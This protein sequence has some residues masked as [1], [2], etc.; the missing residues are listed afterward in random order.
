MY[1][2]YL[3]N[4]VDQFVFKHLLGM[5]VCYKETDIITLS[6]RMM[7][8][9]LKYNHYYYTVPTSMGFLLKTKKCSARIIMKCMNFLHNIFSISSA[10]KKR[11]KE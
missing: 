1:N 6:K 9:I 2:V 7:N 10:F 11:Q 8:I 5:K 3:N 4:K